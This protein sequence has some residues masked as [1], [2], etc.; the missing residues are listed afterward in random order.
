MLFEVPVIE[1]VTVS[2]AVIVCDPAVLRVALK[3]P[4]PLVR[5]E[6]TGS[7][8]APSVEVKCT[9]PAYPVAV[10]LNASSAVTVKLTAHPPRAADRA[11]T[12][13]CVAA[14]GLTLMLFDVPVIDEATVSVA[15]MVCEPAVLSV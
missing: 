9:V 11:V 12:V 10:L 5:V 13:K 6:L 4:V 7:V 15:V 8:A 3:V 1:G 14:A 2:V